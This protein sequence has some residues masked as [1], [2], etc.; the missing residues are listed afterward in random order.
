M[1]TVDWTQ[2][3]KEGEGLVTVDF[4]EV[5]TDY[6]HYNAILFRMDDREVWVP[7]SLINNREDNSFDVPEW[8]AIK[9]ELV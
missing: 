1:T 7:K 4:D 9:E 3:Q 5:I 6:D 2:E 8:F